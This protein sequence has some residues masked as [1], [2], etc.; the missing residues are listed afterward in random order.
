MRLRLQITGLVQGVGF[1]PFVYRLAEE[2]GLNGYVL[3]DTSGVLIEVEGNKDS[4][5]SFLQRIVRERPALSQIYSLQHAYLE[6]TGFNNF[7]IRDSDEQGVKQAYILPDIAVCHDC[8]DDITTPR[9]RRFIYPF[10]NCTNCGP[11]FT[12]INSLP[13]DRRNTSMRDF[14]MCAECEKE[15]NLASDR[16][17]HAQ[18]NAC[19]ACG[20]W[21]GL[22][23]RSGSLIC[24]KEEALEKVVN[25]IRKGNIIA[26]KG[27]GGYHLVC[28]AAS[29][30]AVV[31]LRERKNREEKPMAV[32][33][34][35]MISVKEEVHLNSFEE[36]AIDSIEKPVV[37]VRKKDNSTIA[38]SVSPENNTVGVFLPYTPLHHIILRKLKKPVVATSA[39][40]TDEPI[41]KDEKDAFTRLSGI[42]DYLLTHNRDIL[43][44]CDDSV[45]RIAAERQVPV[46]RSRGFV[47]TPVIMPFKFKRPVLALGANMNNT[48]ALG[49]D[50]RVFVS[51]HIGDLDTPL[52]AEFYE[53]T[54]DDFL[55]LFDIV[56]EVAVADMHPGYFSTK[57]GEKQYGRRLVKVQHH[58][59]HILSCMVENDIPEDAVVTGFAFDGTGY[60]PDRT[61]W[62]G[63][64]LT[65]SYKGFERAFHLRP[66]KLPGGDRA[67]SEPRRT[68]L[69]LLYETFGDSAEQLALVPFSPEE[70]SFLTNML[71]RNINSPATTS[72]GRLFDGVASL[73]GLRHRVSY[74][75]QA[76]VELEQLAFRSDEISAYPF[77]VEN[78]VIDQRSVIEMIVHDIRA[79]APKEVISRKFHNT[80]VKLIIQT[81]ELLKEKTGT[82]YAALSGGVFQNSFLLEN[83]FYG[84]RERGLTP[85]IHQLV[86]P[87]DGGISLGQAVY[88]NSENISREY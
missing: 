31:M 69:S 29:E 41:V 2:S 84:L 79:A 1:R 49:I 77:T 36:R 23:D 67:V 40:I 44:R 62:G 12:I 17:F 54:I 58:Y 33:F 8:I 14:H 60:G 56:P 68:A 10:T 78:G 48:I 25:L 5:D 16:R 57:F 18:P 32:M 87:N 65:A 80:I 34:P 13:Y 11:R 55:R 28:D 38:H 61:I 88:G 86:P 70:R 35:D 76:A 24:E 45:V 59:A 74:H 6:D 47:P 9:N 21:T 81:A 19:P 66:F 51:Q 20:P 72:M 22:H 42:A 73:I 30:E 71:H 15:F 46:R 3:N 7:E 27:I 39:N 83:S 4:L 50:N 75:A 37:I 52:A 53:E 85:V 26:I 82:S 63:E 43:R 64:I